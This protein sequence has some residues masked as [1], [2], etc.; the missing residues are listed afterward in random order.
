MKIINVA[1]PATDAMHLRKVNT[2]QESLI[3]DTKAIMRDVAQHGDSAVLNYTSKFDGAGLDSLRISEEEIKQAYAQV[4]KDQIN[5]VKL[6]KER[7]VKSELAILV[8]LKGLTVSSGGVRID[9]MVKPVASVGCYVPG[10]RARYPSTVI[11]CA[12]PAKVAGVKRIV[13][14]SPPQNDG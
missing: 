3:E 14:I 12:V 6:M 4:T 2:I 13:A 9:R 1:N 5:A 7:L 8:R 11:M 10:G